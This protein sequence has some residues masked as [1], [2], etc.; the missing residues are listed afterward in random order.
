MLIIQ[1][2]TSLSCKMIVYIN[3]GQIF[4]YFKIIP[5]ENTTTGKME[6]LLM[7]FNIAVGYIF[8]NKNQQIIYLYKNY[9]FSADFFTLIGLYYTF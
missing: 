2:L 3:I 7:H 9:Q 6:N 1:L 8:F 4:S 5:V